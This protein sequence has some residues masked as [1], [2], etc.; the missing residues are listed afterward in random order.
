MLLQT[1]FIANVFFLLDDVVE[2]KD[3]LIRDVM[4]WFR[5]KLA[6]DVICRHLATFWGNF[7]YFLSEPVG[8]TG[9]KF[10]NKSKPKAVCNHQMMKTFLVISELFVGST[11][12]SSP[13]YLLYRKYHIYTG[14]Y[15]ASLVLRLSL[16]SVNSRVFHFLHFTCHVATYYSKPYN[17]NR[18]LYCG[19]RSRWA[20]GLQGFCLTHR[21]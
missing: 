20:W 8:N 6:R 4:T 2:N 14:G 1:V 17:V 12:F 10:R 9:N 21:N 19:V 5:C 16:L 18:L 15:K 3:R 7:T 13:D 11:Y